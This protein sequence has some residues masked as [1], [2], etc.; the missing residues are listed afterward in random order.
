M[1][2]KKTDPRYQF[3]GDY[4]D[5]KNK[6]SQMEGKI[7]NYMGKPYKK[8]IDVHLA[9]LTALFDKAEKERA[10]VSDEFGNSV[11]I[12]QWYQDRPIRIELSHDSPIW[13]DLLNYF[14]QEY[15]GHN[16]DE[17]TITR[18]AITELPSAGLNNTINFVE[19]RDWAS[20]IW[21]I[22]AFSPSAFK[23]AIY[24]TDVDEDSG[25]YEHIKYPEQHFFAE[26]DYRKYGTRFRDLDNPES[27]KVLGEKYDTFI[28][29]PTVLHKGNYARTKHRDAI[30]VGFDHIFELPEN[31]KKK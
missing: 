9:R 26:F 1:F 15:E 22:D 16:C 2:L 19:G 30:M 12:T 6:P 28:F 20:E 21:H 7:I 17:L 5:Y 31:I 25:P 14:R 11:F 18:N 13:I 23:I 10:E 3:L 29:H 8:I 4:R 27:I 24:L